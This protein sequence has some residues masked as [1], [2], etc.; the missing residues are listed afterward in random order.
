MR[1]RGQ[2][3]SLE[4]EWDEVWAE[5]DARLARRAAP[6]AP[7]AVLPARPEPEAVALRRGGGRW[8][9]GALLLLLPVLWFLAPIVTA[10]QVGKAFE[11][12]DVQAFARHVDGTAVAADMRARL[13]EVAARV[14]DGPANAFLDSMA[15][16]IAQAWSNPIAV[17]GQARAAMAP[18]RLVSV[19]VTGFELELA[20]RPAPV[21]LRFE[22]QAS[23]TLPRW[24]VTG[25]RA[26]TPVQPF[27]A[28]PARLSAR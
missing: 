11:A 20:A 3:A 26:E 12:G 28:A 23:G 27:A 17:A 6:V 8:A 24:Q 13:A 5:H 25:V 1:G 15:E 7:P 16:D 4:S 2:V 10:W 22:L 9:L 14:P 19:G 21:T 18:P